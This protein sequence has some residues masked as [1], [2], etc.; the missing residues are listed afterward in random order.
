MSLFLV[1]R[2]QPEPNRVEKE[3]IAI[4]ADDSV[5]SG[6]GV[7]LIEFVENTEMSLKL[8]S[9]NGN[10]LTR[11][12]I[13]SWTMDEPEMGIIYQLQRSTDGQVYERIKNVPGKNKEGAKYMYRDT[14]IQKDTI[15]YYRVI[16]IDANKMASHSQPIKVETSLPREL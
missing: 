7:D 3:V 11:S 14:S 2:F 5:V 8:S 12:I 6:R 15:Y 13:V 4:V 9:L 16:I 10:F 1:A